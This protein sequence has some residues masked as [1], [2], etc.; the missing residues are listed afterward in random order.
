MTIQT[1][2]ENKQKSVNI[3][4]LAAK[5]CYSV[6]DQGRSLG[7]ELPKRQ[8]KSAAK[9]KGLLQE[10]CYGVLR[11]LPELEHDV[12]GLMQKPLTGKQR[13]FHFL[14]LVRFSTIPPLN[15]QR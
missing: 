14:L 6:V 8:E 1:P 2:Q 10:I 4:A 3:R 11:Y 13:V 12:R 7:D 9:D 5:C 15:S